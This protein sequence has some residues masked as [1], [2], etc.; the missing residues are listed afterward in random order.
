[1]ARQ[2]WTGWREHDGKGCPV[3]RGT[4]VAAIIEYPSGRTIEACFDVNHGAAWDH[5]N[6]G[7]PA[8]TPAGVEGNCARILR[9]RVWQ[10]Y[11]DAA[12]TC[13][14]AALAQAARHKKA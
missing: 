13:M 4:T 11:Y 6:F 7:A 8:V 2:A 10:T 1:M 9:Y 3:P 12:T 14:N 5:K